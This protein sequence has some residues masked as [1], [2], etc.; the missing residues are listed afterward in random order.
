MNSDPLAE[1]LERTGNGPFT[2]TES[3][4]GLLQLSTAQLIASS[5]NRQRLREALQALEHHAGTPA[6]AAQDESA[7][8]FGL[9]AL[10][11][12]QALA[13]ALLAQE[14]CPMSPPPLDTQRLVTAVRD[15]KHAPEI[16]RVLAADG[17]SRPVNVRRAVGVNDMTLFRVLSWAMS[18]GLVLRSAPDAAVHY[19]LSAL[20]ETVLEA[21]DEPRWL[22][23]ATT[24]MRIS[25]RQQQMSHDG[26]P[27][28]LAGAQ[29]PL[30]EEASMLTGLSQAQA[31]RSLFEF[32]RALQP[33]AVT[34]L[35]AAL[36]YAPHMGHHDIIISPP[37]FPSEWWDPFDDQP[38]PPELTA[39][40]GSWS[41]RLDS[42]A[43]AQVV[44]AVERAGIPSRELREV[45]PHHYLRASKHAN[46]QTSR[47][48]LP[49]D[50]RPIIS[51]GSPEVN[52]MTTGLFYEYGASVHLR[53]PRRLSIA[54]P[55]AARQQPDPAVLWQEGAKHV[56][57]VPSSEYDYGL[58]LRI[59]DD[60]TGLTHFV[61]G[62][63]LP[64][65]TYAACRYFH[66][67]IE[68]RLEQF[69]QQSFATLLRVPRSYG[70]RKAYE[71]I[72]SEPVITSV[73][74]H[75][76][77]MRYVE[78]LPMLS[79]ALLAGG[80]R[81]HAHLREAMEAARGEG[82]DL[83]VVRT[84]AAGGGDRAAPICRRVRDT[85]VAYSLLG[86]FEELVVLVVNGVLLERTGSTHRD[87]GWNTTD[88]TGVVGLSKFTAAAVSR[89][90]GGRAGQGR[91]TSVPRV[92]VP[93]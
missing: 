36:R 53:K 54:L 72:R 26:R 76:L 10:H 31:A 86:R 43:E 25:V 38:R 55:L 14:P 23:I 87:R 33:A 29:A 90:L 68:E 59:H 93:A 77:D 67:E 6:P 2:P 73:N 79:E 19:R 64:S 47:Y 5:Y 9:T 32:S 91:G 69:P 52:P 21:L 66:H 78:V 84:L 75:P 56:E 34:K 28:D 42:L 12:L 20:G 80:E 15:K 49:R 17:D 4:I 89:L 51:I 37:V 63:L 18:N 48:H 1:L 7:P 85:A 58:L 30:V 35:A 8:G 82:V 57:H 40:R 44:R 70:R 60:H 81:I 16:L 3:D 65:G 11:A 39:L 50:S 62:G 83:D 71:C 46:R 74:P 24:L 27:W 41:L 61:M 22:S 88:L 45:L 92:P 13:R